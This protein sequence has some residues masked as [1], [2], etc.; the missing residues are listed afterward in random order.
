MCVV[1]KNRFYSKCP[2]HLPLSLSVSNISIA[3]NIETLKSTS[4][5]VKPKPLLTYFN[6]SKPN[7]PSSTISMMPAQY[8]YNQSYNRVIHT[9]VCFKC[10][11]WFGA[12]T[13]LRS[14]TSAGIR[15]FSPFSAFERGNTENAP[16]KRAIAPI[17]IGTIGNLIG[18]IFPPS[19]SS[20][21]THCYWFHENINFKI[22]HTWWLFIGAD[23]FIGALSF[24]SSP[25]LPF[26]PLNLLS[27]SLSL[28]FSSLFPHFYH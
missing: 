12:R 10:I 23:F 4:T 5:I 2:N 27:L 17:G 22:E 3:L 6:L 13:N 14:S 1:F 11:G 7:R 21:Q 24:C 19:P 9:R 20:S 28:H 8:T 15:V 16:S 26:P 18:N 25:L